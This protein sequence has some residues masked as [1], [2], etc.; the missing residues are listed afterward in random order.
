MARSLRRS[1]RRAEIAVWVV[2]MAAVYSVL[3]MVISF[4]PV[5][6]VGQAVVKWM[7]YLHPAGAGSGLLL[8]ETDVAGAV[9]FPGNALDVVA[10]PEIA[11]GAVR[12]NILGNLDNVLGG[13]V[14]LAGSQVIQQ[15]L[16][17]GVIPAGVPVL[18]NA[19]FPKAVRGQGA[20][21]LV[22]AHGLLSFLKPSGRPCPCS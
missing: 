21:F 10:L 14:G 11:G 19:E 17:L 7:V 16:I 12:D 1:V 8:L 4:L 6:P 5:D 2:A 9:D 3:V 15:V 18:A 22:A 20:D 13:Q